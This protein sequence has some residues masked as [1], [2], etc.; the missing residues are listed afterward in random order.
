[1]SDSS[2]VDSSTSSPFLS[3]KNNWTLVINFI[4]N[5]WFDSVR[6]YKIKILLYKVL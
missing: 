6:K 2:L 5:E 3:K 1:M 4:I